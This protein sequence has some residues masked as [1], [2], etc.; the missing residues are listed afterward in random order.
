MQTLW[1]YG[2][3]GTHWSTAAETVCENTYEEG[4]FH[5][6]ESL[7]SPGIQ[8]TKNNIDPMLSIGDY[9]DADPGANQIAEEARES[10]E[11]FNENSTLAPSVKS[12]DEM[13]QFNGDLTTLKNSIIADIVT[14]GMSV[15]EGYQRF[16]DEG[17]AM[18]PEDRGLSERGIKRNRADCGKKEEFSR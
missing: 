5:M 18:V 15:E 12:T 16:E 11:I 6:L 13:S 2:V 1:T 9:I 3:E 10:Q 17:G 7:E 4:E 8:Y 14:Q